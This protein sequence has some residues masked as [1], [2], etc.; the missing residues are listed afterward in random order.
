M[1]IILTENSLKFL[2]GNVINEAV[3][4]P[5]NIYQTAV[6]IYDEII[7]Q[8]KTLN[9]ESFTKES[10]NDHFFYQKNLE[11]NKKLTIGKQNFFKVHKCNY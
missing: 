5:N 3:G 6:F 11:I 10:E 8:L 2:M 9:S 4:V 7:T 1:N